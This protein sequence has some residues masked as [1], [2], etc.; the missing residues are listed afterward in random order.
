MQ[1]GHLGPGLQRIWSLKLGDYM[2]KVFVST[3]LCTTV[4]CYQMYDIY[5][6][7][8]NKQVPKVVLKGLLA[9]FCCMS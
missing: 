1:L 7:P 2:L 9:K 6:V 4:V 5:W 8:G 3:D